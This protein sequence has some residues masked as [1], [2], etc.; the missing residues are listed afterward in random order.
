MPINS[1]KQP[2]KNHFTLTNHQEPPA[3]RGVCTC[4]PKTRI[5]TQGDL[6]D[7]IAK[8]LVLKLRHHHVKEQ[9]MNLEF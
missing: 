6:T 7:Q 4:S 1:T 8:F 2:C 3:Q 9:I 5:I